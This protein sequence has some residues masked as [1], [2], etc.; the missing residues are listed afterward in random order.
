MQYF[1][2]YCL[3]LSLMQPCFATLPFGARRETRGEISQ[4]G[5]VLVDAVTHDFTKIR[6]S[7]KPR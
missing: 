7:V 3:A 6:G 1:H 5:Y 4:R 2:E